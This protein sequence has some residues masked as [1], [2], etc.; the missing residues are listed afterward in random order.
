MRP[1][2]GLDNPTAGEQF[3]EPGIAVG[4]DDAAEL[5]QMRLRML[6]FAVGRVEE[7]SRRFP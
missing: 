5:P 3:I 4:V 2:A 7:Q 1:A 6:T